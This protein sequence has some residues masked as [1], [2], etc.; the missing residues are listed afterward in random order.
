MLTTEQLPPPSS[1]SPAID[2]ESCLNTSPWGS[3]RTMSTV[4]AMG[5]AAFLL[6]SLG[7]ATDGNNNPTLLGCVYAC[8]DEQRMYGSLQKEEYNGMFVAFVKWCVE[9]YRI[10]GL[11]E[12][13]LTHG[14]TREAKYLVDLL[15]QTHPQSALKKEW[16]NVVA[17]NEHEMVGGIV[18]FTARGVGVKEEVLVQFDKKT[19][20]T[21]R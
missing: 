18:V 12:H 13:A 16:N 19:S 15:H 4:V 6:L 2:A 7:G 21:G 8:I 20:I 11:L 1:V 17:N 10:Q 14:R 3:V 9:K 5:G